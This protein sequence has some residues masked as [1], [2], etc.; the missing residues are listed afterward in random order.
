MD[1]FRGVLCTI[2]VV[3]EVYFFS[4]KFFGMT[5]LLNSIQNWKKKKNV[6]HYRSSKRFVPKYVGPVIM[7]LIRDMS[8]KANRALSKV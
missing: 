7:G 8:S 2:V 1:V 4:L 5:G 6:P 3:V